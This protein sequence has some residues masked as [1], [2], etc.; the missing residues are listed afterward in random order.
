MGYEKIYD[1]EGLL[2]KFYEGESSLGE[3]EALRDFTADTFIDTDDDKA[4]AVMSELFRREREVGYPGNVVPL[5]RQKKFGILLRSAAAAVAAILVVLGA[6]MW[7]PVP[8][9]VYCFIDGKPI[10][11]HETAMEHSHTA[12]DIVS[13]SLEKSAAMFDQLDEVGR[14]VRALEQAGIFDD[15]NAPDT[16]DKKS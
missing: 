10:T 1:T 13:E 5:R 3:E 8:Q 9:K 14:A 15:L 16:K 2:R 7:N 4:A 12:I 11:D 6:T